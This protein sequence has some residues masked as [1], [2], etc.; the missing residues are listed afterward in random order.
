MDNNFTKTE[1]L[2]QFMDGELDKEQTDALEKN[3]RE[4]ASMADEL[5]S[6]RLAKDTVKRYGLQNRIHAIN[7]EMMD[8][9]S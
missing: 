2:I 7:A 4:D 6:L 3:I 1:L 8:E 5:E 9:L